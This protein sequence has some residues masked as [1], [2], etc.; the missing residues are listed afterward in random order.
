MK[1]REPGAVIL[2]S[3]TMWISLILESL[4]HLLLD[5]DVAKADWRRFVVIRPTSAAE[6]CDIF[7]YA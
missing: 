2:C 1:I 3:F 5:L 6:I 7:A 4:Y